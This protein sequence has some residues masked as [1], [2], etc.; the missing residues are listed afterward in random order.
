MGL[1]TKNTDKIYTMF[2]INSIFSGQIPS[3]SIVYLRTFFLYR[4]L[5]T[6]DKK[7]YF[8]HY[9]PDKYS[10]LWYISYDEPKNRN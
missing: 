5:V 4:I 3:G 2:F 6:F 10:L 1:T 7:E 8:A 9:E